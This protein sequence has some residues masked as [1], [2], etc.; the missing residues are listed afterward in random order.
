MPEQNS[1]TIDKFLEGFSGKGLDASFDA[2]QSINMIIEVCRKIPKSGEYTSAVIGTR[3]GEYVFAIQECGKLLSS[4]GLVR[5]Y[6]ETEVDKAF[7]RAALEKAPTMGYTTDGKS[8]L[9]AQMD[10]EYI[11]A[12]NKL[13][14]IQAVITYIE[15]YS[16]SLNLAHLHCKKIIDR[17]RVEERFA[18]DHERYSIANKEIV[19]MDENDVK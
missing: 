11:I 6:Q 2:K 15:N 4:L 12:K 8:K 1:T 5:D 9:Y 3:I 16:K 17:D 18:N 7:A 13:S 14:E 19:W 10:E